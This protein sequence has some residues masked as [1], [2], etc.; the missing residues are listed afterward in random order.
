M[1]AGI[2]SVSIGV[3]TA[4]GLTVFAAR[5]TIRNRRARRQEVR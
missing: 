1:I 4:A 3:L 2:V 5:E